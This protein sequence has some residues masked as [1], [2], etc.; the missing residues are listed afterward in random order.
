MTRRD[1][2]D[3][4]VKDSRIAVLKAAEKLT[5]EECE[6]E[7]FDIDLR[8]A[9]NPAIG[10][11]GG[12]Y[13]RWLYFKQLGPKVYRVWEEWDAGC[14]ITGYDHIDGEVAL[15]APTLARLE[16]LPLDD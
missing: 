4:N 10:A 7:Y 6:F 15:D 14:S 11:N 5:G 3:A 12:D 8:V 2:L 9:R 13:N 1:W 16:A